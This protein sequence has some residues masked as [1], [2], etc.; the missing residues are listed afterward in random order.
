MQTIQHAL[1]MSQ[2]GRLKPAIAVLERMTQKRGAPPDAYHFLGVLQS[3]IGRLDQALFNLERASKMAP[4]RPQFE[5]NHA[6]VLTSAGRMEEALEHYRLALDAD[7]A[8][9]P[10]R[11][12]LAGVLLS[13]GRLCDAE[14]EAREAHR[15]APDNPEAAANLGSCLIVTGRAHE[16][17]K[18]LRTAIDTL[19]PSITLNTLLTAAMNY[20]DASTP[21]QLLETHRTLGRLHTLAA[22]RFAGDLPELKTIDPSAPRLRIGY[23]SADFRDHPVAAFL[24][25]ALASD[26]R[27]EVFCYDTTPH[28]DAWS[29]RLRARTVTWREAASLSD[30]ELVSMARS[31]GIDLL[32]ELSGHSVGNRQTALAARMAPVQVSMLGYPA[33]TGNPAIDA[34][35]VDS[36]TDPD[37]AEVW[38]SERLIRLDPCAWCYSE[39]EHAPQV[40]PLPAIERGRISFGSFNNLAK[41]TPGVLDVWARLL[42]RVPGSRLV[43]KNAAFTDEPTRASIVGELTARGVE[44]DRIEPLA[45]T[46]DTADHMAA[47]AHVDIAL[48]TFPY[49]GTTTTCE[50]LWMGV[51]VVT[52]SGQLHAGRVG[53]SL[54]FAVGLEECIASDTER[55]IEIA[56]ALASDMEKLATLRTSLRARMKASYLMDQT[57]FCDRLHGAYAALVRAQ[58]ATR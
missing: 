44:V 5:S 23:L 1:A 37:G 6:G 7:D 41:T 39:P 50:A 51:P 27:V 24:E 16:A 25:P 40:L 28:Q 43:L 46:G 26:D 29:A 12:G 8:Y 13:L 10:A 31:D 20:D 35:V 47:Y 55:Y 52:L 32:V 11:V 45:P 38:C 54:L 53:V 30:A 34:R 18:A 14:H 19:G 42:A 56:A 33:T 3:R 2:Q 49:A 48:D 4:G 21:E 15:L 57:A 36:R 22:K 58:G 9:A 17:V